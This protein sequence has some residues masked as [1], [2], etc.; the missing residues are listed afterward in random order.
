M[1]ARGAALSI[2]FRVAD[3][4]SNVFVRSSDGEWFSARGSLGRSTLVE[5][6][7]DLNRDL[8]AFQEVLGL[9]LQQEDWEVVTRAVRVLFK[10]GRLMCKL[11]FGDKLTDAQAL[12]TKVL[13]TPDQPRT[14][15]SQIDLRADFHT[16]PPF[17]LLP[18]LDLSEPAWCIDS[19]ATLSAVL[20]R[21]LGFS[22]IIRRIYRGNGGLD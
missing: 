15:W 12:F 13:R 20:E 7:T 16:A 4:H 10:R 22:T 8:Q 6:R 19:D 18:I 5:F 21:F 1:T 9:E 17:E 11:I 2:D 14:V 3:D